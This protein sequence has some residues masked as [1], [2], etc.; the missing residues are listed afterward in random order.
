MLLKDFDGY[1]AF[2][3]YNSTVEGTKPEEAGDADL[4]TWGTNRNAA[5]GLGDADDR[6]HP[7]QV[8]IQPQKEYADA[9]KRTIAERLT[10]IC[11]KQISMA[12][13]HTGTSSCLHV[14]SLIE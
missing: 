7:E 11:V 4:F 12:K 13:L 10:P 8:V 6:A 3:L 2:D 9:E 5:L 1:T 14:V